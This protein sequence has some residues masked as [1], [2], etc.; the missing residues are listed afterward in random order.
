V[1]IFKILC[2]RKSVTELFV[3]SKKCKNIPHEVQFEQMQHFKYS[4]YKSVK[5]TS[6]GWLYKIIFFISFKKRKKVWL[7]DIIWSM[8]RNVGTSDRSVWTCNKPH[9]S[10]SSTEKIA[11][12]LLVLMDC[13]WTSFWKNPSTHWTAAAK[14]EGSDYLLKTHR[15]GLWRLR[16]KDTV[17]AVLLGHSDVYIISERVCTLLIHIVM[18]LCE[19]HGHCSFG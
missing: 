10:A 2:L 8:H 7:S 5:L 12:G 13:L 14:L 11:G 9:L 4:G 17:Y 18:P 1:Y 19:S 15:N 16:G 6:F 3:T